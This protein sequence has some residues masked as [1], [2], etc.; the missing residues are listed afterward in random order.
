M[1]FL[2]TLAGIG[3]SEWRGEDSLARW[4]GTIVA[5]VIWNISQKRGWEP[6]RIEM[7]TAAN[8]VSPSTAEIAPA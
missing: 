2:C 8:G 5:H 3:R 6:L 1:C 4:L 7:A